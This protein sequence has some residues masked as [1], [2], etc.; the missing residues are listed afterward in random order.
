MATRKNSRQREMILKTL[1]HSSDHPS[2]EAIYA[3]VKK[4]LP[5]LAL[6]TVYRNLRILKEEGL[7]IELNGADGKTHYD[8]N[9]RQHHHF[10]CEECGRIIDLVEIPDRSIEDMLSSMVGSDII[11]T[12]I[13]LKGLC[14]DCKKER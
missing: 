8:Y 11:L 6:G 3:Q 5:N 13:K 10:I 9:T 7:L 4:V 14:P 1:I 12:S 2:A